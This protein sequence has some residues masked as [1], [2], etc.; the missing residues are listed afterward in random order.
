MLNV[1]SSVFEWLYSALFVGS[2]LMSSLTYFGKIARAVLKR[3]YPRL[4]LKSAQ[5]KVFKGIPFVHVEVR[6]LLKFNA[7]TNIKELQ[8]LS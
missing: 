1:L 6:P 2:P 5:L 8:E 7:R 3:I 4:V